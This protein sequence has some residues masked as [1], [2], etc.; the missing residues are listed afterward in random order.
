MSRE[1]LPGDPHLQRADA[2]LDLGRVAAALEQ[3]ELAISKEPERA[4]GYLEAGRALLRLDR[5][6]EAEVQVRAGLARDP[7]IAWAHSLLSAVLCRLDRPQEGL[8]AVRE[9]L[10]RAPDVGVFRV[11]LAHNLLQ[12][13]DLPAARTAARQATLHDPSESWSHLC[14]ARMS[15][16]RPAELGQARRAIDQACALDPDQPAVLC[17]L[18]DVFSAEFELGQARQAY[19]QAVRADPTDWYPKERFLALTHLG[20]LAVVDGIRAVGRLLIF[21]LLLSII[22]G[23]GAGPLTSKLSC[24]AGAVAGIFGPAW[25]L[26]HAGRLRMEEELPGSWATYQAARAEQGRRMGWWRRLLSKLIPTH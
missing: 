14:L 10:K 2:L 25:L 19:H 15:L 18:G 12:L 26:E 22:G 8:V 11:R 6:T 1:P 4:E 9:A 16:A 13:G 24:V 5:A 3:A 20:P 21:V 23:T 17:T 7:E